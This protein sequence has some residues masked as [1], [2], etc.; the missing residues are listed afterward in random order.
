MTSQPYKM[1]APIPEE[2]T[3]PAKVD[4]SIGP[5]DF[6]DGYPS[7][8][9]LQLVYDNLDRQRAIEV[10]LD[11][12][13]AAS[14]VA[15]HHGLKEVGAVD[16][17]VGIWEELLDAKSLILTGNTES[18]YAFTWLDTS[19][20]PLVIESPPNVLGVIDDAWFRYVADLGNAGPDKGKGGK[21]LLL[22]PGYKGKV[23]EGYFVL[24]SPTYNNWLVW[25]G[26]PVNGDPK[27]AADNI[28][29]AARIY[30]L[31]GVGNT[32]A[33]KFVDVSGRAF[34]TIHANDAHF[35][36]ELNEVIQAEPTA[37]FDPEILGMAASIGLEKGK[38]FQPDAR[39]QK[40]LADA[41]AIA[42]AT[43]RAVAFA[44][45]DPTAVLFLGT[46]WKTA[47]LGG[48]YEW[49][50]NGHRY[51]DARTGFFYAATV[52]TPAM[53]VAM[54]GVGSQYATSM[55]DSKGRWLDGGKNYI[56]H[57][58][59]NP[60]AKDFWSIVIY[61]PQT[62]SLLQTDQ[63]FPSLGSHSADLVK[64]V[65]GSVD[66][67]FGPKPPAGK[68]HNWIQTV[69]DKGWFTIFRLYGPL[70]SW[71]DR[72]WMLEDFVDSHE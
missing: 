10:F 28:K 15:M 54:P 5:L 43:A 21:F 56:L 70:K 52:N 42:N 3:T 24:H 68:E 62:R 64:N 69:P 51:L 59:P 45:R 41:A 11:T 49:L 19:K 18:V 13:P 9:T 14:L 32:Y 26:F 66:L 35:Y 36:E 72:S 71:F 6:F 57:I 27:P 61:D 34:N 38:P 12:I 39:M 2:I 47:F 50:S 23:P 65:D 60:P 63:H 46:Q 48:S 53:V 58:A 29:R 1:A 55:R 30:P 31:S 20:G 44:P 17:T 16:G 67:Y 33:G 25:R 40:I 8:K 37:A 4:T 22:P 7:D